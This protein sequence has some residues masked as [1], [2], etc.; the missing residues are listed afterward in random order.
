M[1]LIL[2][3]VEAHEGAPAALRGAVLAYARGVRERASVI[4]RY[5]INAEGITTNKTYGRRAI[6]EGELVWD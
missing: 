4:G 2:D 5:S 1:A 3:A 6:V